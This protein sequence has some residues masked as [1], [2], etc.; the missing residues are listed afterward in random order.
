MTPPFLISTPARV[1]S[2][3]AGMGAEK[4]WPAPPTADGDA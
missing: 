2:S 4:T 1:I 3:A